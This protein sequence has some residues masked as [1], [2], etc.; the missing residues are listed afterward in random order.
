MCK[1]KTNPGSTKVCVYT[2][3]FQTN[4]DS[5]LLRWVRF[6]PGRTRVSLC[7]V[8]RALLFLLIGALQL[9]VTWYKIQNIEEKRNVRDD[10][11]TSARY[12]ETPTVESTIEGCK[13]QNSP[14]IKQLYSNGWCKGLVRGALSD[15]F[16]FWKVNSLAYRHDEAVQC[17][18]RHNSPN[19]H[20]TGKLIYK[21]N[22]FYGE[23]SQIA[24]GL[25][26]Q[27][28]NKKKKTLNKTDAR[29]IS[30]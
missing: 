2:T 19:Q 11:L 27:K 5:T 21:R 14:K 3:L 10:S 6:N 7:R 30:A 18:V 29:T 20:S 24:C 13:G 9:E 23:T 1:I 12:S 25:P 28:T 15:Y 8:D 16:S 26:V 17:T 4:P 22:I